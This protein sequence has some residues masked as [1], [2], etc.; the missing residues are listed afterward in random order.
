MISGCIGQVY[1]LRLR[2]VAKIFCR[3][4]LEFRLATGR[5]E[6]EALAFMPGKVLCRGAVD[7]HAADRVGGGKILFRPG[8]EFRKAALAAEMIEMAAMLGCRL[9]GGRIDGHAADRIANDGA[10]DGWGSFRRTA[11]TL[12][13]GVLIVVG[14]R[15][16]ECL[17]L[18][19]EA[20][21]MLP[22]TGRSRAKFVFRAVSAMPN[23][24]GGKSRMQPY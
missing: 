17:Y 2:P 5:A 20:E 9:A 4:R 10:R 24:S 15:H 6:I 18:D 13:V 22:V 7:A 14:M 12:C 19:A 3:L 23:G 8:R 1:C 21:V 16:A 11:G